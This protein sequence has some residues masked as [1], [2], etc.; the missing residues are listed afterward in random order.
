AVVH[1][2]EFI[3]SAVPGSAPGTYSL[4]I[5]TAAAANYTLSFGTS[6]LVVLPR[7]LT[8]AANDATRFYGDENPEFTATF[9]GLA[10]FDSEE[11][12]PD[13]EITSTATPASGAQQ[14]AIIPSRA[15]NPNYAITFVPG[16]L[17]IAQA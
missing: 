10:S 7:P 4:G 9:D 3:S 8:I 16:T 14:L 6:T 5:A 2:L 17:T 11:D 15:T 13:L 1:N 12:F